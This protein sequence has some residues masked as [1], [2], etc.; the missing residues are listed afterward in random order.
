M[1]KS[2]NFNGIANA[3]SWMEKLTFGKSLARCRLALL[4]DLLHSHNALVIGD[5]DGRFTARLLEANPAVL[6]DA[7]DASPAMLRALVDNA[8]IRASRVRVHVADARLWEPLVPRLDLIATHFFLD[9][10]TTNEVASLAKRLRV[11]ARPD[12]KWVVSEFAI[13]EGA[14]G[15]IVA[16][17]LIMA[18]YIAF[19]V[20]TGLRVFRL[21]DHR[22]ALSQAGFMLAKQ[23]RFL[24]GLLVSE[25][26]TIAPTSTVQQP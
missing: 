16:R 8:G 5:G 13:P 4:G 11:A 19:A 21:P 10:L 23:R 24:H 1:K 20:L 7:L 26:W 14:F 12:A 17:P 6:V 18:L 2:P 25:L 22:T 15:S 3:Y 9:C